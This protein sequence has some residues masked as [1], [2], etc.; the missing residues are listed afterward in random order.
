MQNLKPFILLGL[1]FGLV[2]VTSTVTADEKGK[3]ENEAV[4]DGAAKKTIP[5][6]V[7]DV[8]QGC[9]PLLQEGWHPLLR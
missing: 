1:L 3:D 8:K 4:V 7:D 6:E 2:L 9:G 5:V